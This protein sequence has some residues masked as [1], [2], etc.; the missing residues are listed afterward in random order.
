MAVRGLGQ[1]GRGISLSGGR[2]YLG[3]DGTSA[4]SSVIKNRAKVG[5]GGDSRSR[6]RRHLAWYN[7]G[8]ATRVSFAGGGKP[9]LSQLSELGPAFDEATADGHQ[10]VRLPTLTRITN[11]AGGT[12]GA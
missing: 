7:K 6:Y 10:P 8:H 11:T 1:L 9:I 4:A 2:V 12:P 3:A 5:T